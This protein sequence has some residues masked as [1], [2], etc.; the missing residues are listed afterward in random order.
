M[1]T[2]MCATLNIDFLIFVNYKAK[3]AALILISTKKI[4]FLEVLAH[5]YFI[6]RN[7]M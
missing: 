6:S 2:R 4:K 3:I 7:K 5:H 1:A